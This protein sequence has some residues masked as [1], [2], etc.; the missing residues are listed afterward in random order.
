[1]IAI[2]VCPPR[3]AHRIQ[4]IKP[5]PLDTSAQETLARLIEKESHLLDDKQRIAG[6]LDGLAIRERVTQFRLEIVQRNIQALR[7]LV[8][9]LEP[10]PF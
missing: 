6:L 9:E 1:M 3:P 7:Q 2:P 5:D 10:L 8:G 4:G